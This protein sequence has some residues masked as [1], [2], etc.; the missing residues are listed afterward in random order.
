MGILIEF[1]KHKK[2]TQKQ[3]EQLETLEV[4]LNM[5]E[6]RLAPHSLS[7]YVIYENRQCKFSILA[8]KTTDSCTVFFMNKENK[9][10]Q[11]LKQI[12]ITE[13]IDFLM[14]NI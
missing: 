14:K 9:Y 2:P 13:T 6:Y 7:T 8:R 10:M 12:T 4:S 1:F 5:L 3:I 11:K